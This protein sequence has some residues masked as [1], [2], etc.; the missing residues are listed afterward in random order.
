[1]R[2]VEPGEAIQNIKSGDSV[3]IHSACAEPQT[4]IEA[5]IENKHNLMGVKLFTTVPLGKCEYLD[6]SMKEH[7]T[8]YTFNMSPK[9]QE[10]FIEGRMEYIP[11]RS[12]EVPNLFNEGILPLDVALIQVSPPDKDGYCS[13]G[14]SVDYT[15]SAALNAKIVIGE[16]NDQMPRT[17]GK[18]LLHISQIHYTVESSRPL[19]S[20]DPPA[21]GETEK[22]IADYVC[23]L[24][25]DGATLQIGIGNIPEAILSFLPQEKCR[26]IHTGLITD[27]IM[28]LLKRGGV[29]EK[30]TD[31][32]PIVTT[33]MMGSKYLYDFVHLNPLIEVHPIEFV[34]DLWTI[35]QLKGFVSLNSA[36]EIDLTGQVN[37]ETLGGLMVGGVGGQMD[38]TN[39][40][41]R[42]SN[43]RSIIALPSTSRDE[44]TSRIVP[45]LGKGSVVTIPRYDVDYVVTEYGWCRLKGKSLRQRALELANIAHPKFREGLIEKM[46]LLRF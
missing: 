12:S 5:L 16:I 42:S 46:P 2:R 27:S 1:M 37:A 19:I 28:N 15:L 38:F 39:G 29:K 17:F 35:G 8:L 6:P 20:L 3:F 4:L 21:F 33:M 43:G 26:R 25:P 13:L 7:F 45:S 24:I 10:A 14:I 30:G 32:K 23:E 9:T 36:L 11:V 40:A 41:S 44:N 34:Q 22:R 18:S 31:H